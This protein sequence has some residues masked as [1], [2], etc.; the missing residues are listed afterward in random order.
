[1]KRVVPIV[2]LL[3]TAL[4]VI[5]CV[6]LVT[7]PL[8]GASIQPSAA[9]SIPQPLKVRKEEALAVKRI[10][11][12]NAGINLKGEDDKRFYNTELSVLMSE[13]ENQKRFTIISPIEFKRKARELGLLEDISIM[14]EDELRKEAAYVAKELGCDGVLVLYNK[15]KKVAVGGALVQTAF[16]GTVSVPV[17][18]LLRFISSQTS[19]PTYHQE[20]EVTYT[21]GGMGIKNTPDDELRKMVTPA[22]QLLVSD[23]LKHF[24]SP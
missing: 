17:V 3:G 23:F 14:T 1:M 24:S 9:V 5:G 6:G 18:V 19:S 7:G 15:T 11:I 12:P 20:L 13:L 16:A 21:T 10:A 2:V 22:V 4:W 8:T